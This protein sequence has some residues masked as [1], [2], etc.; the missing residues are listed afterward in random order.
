MKEKVLKIEPFTETRYKVGDKVFSSR[1]SANNYIEML[2]KKTLKNKLD[3]MVIGLYMEMDECKKEIK[4]T[5]DA[6]KEY[7]MELTDEEK[8]EIA[9]ETFNDKFS[10]RQHDAYFDRFIDNVEMM[11]DTFGYAN[12]MVIIGK[13]HE[14]M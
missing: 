1:S 10:L 7:A 11:F 14:A 9:W 3:D 6:H 13:I 12:T 5:V 2:R 8:E 4:Q